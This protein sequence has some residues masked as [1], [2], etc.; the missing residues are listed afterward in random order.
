MTAISCSRV[1]YPRLRRMKKRSS[2]ASG[3]GK[4]PKDS[5]GFW[6]AM[7][8]KGSSNFVVTPSTVTCRSSMA[9]RRA[10]WVRGVARL[11][12]SA[13]TTLVSR[14]PGRKSNSPVFWL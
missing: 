5:R 6:V 1:M 2:W 3:R 12:S 10:D 4:V 9:S 13:S 7:T 14:G 11:I 8:R